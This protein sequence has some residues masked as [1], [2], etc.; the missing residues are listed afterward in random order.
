[1]SEAAAWD[2]HV[3]CRDCG[4]SFAIGSPHGDGAEAYVAHRE[5]VHREVVDR[6]ATVQMF[7]QL[8]LVRWLMSRFPKLSAEYVSVFLRVVEAHI[9]DDHE[10]NWRKLREVMEEKAKEW[11]WPA[12]YVDGLWDLAMATRRAALR[13]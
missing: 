7:R 11:R 1:M 4:T 13:N 12:D 3:Q 10:E 5:S 6:D 2:G 9:R 8:A